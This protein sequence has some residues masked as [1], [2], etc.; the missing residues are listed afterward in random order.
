[1][2]HLSCSDLDA[3]DSILTSVWALN[4]YFS[5]IVLEKCCCAR[6]RFDAL[7]NLPFIRFDSNSECKPLTCLETRVD[8]P[9]MI[10]IRC[11]HTNCCLQ[12]DLEEASVKHEHYIFAVNQ[13]Y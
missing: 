1:M 8:K 6:G 5:R 10:Y 2:V 9:S 4:S 13:Q 12:Q 11:A 7:A 3:H